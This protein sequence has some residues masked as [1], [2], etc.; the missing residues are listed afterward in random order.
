MATI[1]LL[2]NLIATQADLRTNILAVVGVGLGILA[3]LLV[4]IVGLLTADGYVLIRRLLR[5]VPENKFGICS[6]FSQGTAAPE[7]TPR[8]EDLQLDPDGSLAPKPLTTWLADELDAL[9]GI[10][11]SVRPLTMKN[12]AAKGC[13]LR[14]FTT[15]L[16]DGTPYTIPFR[17]RTFCLRSH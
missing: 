13:N 10:T 16:T 1:A 9:A 12:L 17:Q 3:G 15:N 2:A 6:G 7:D 11:D 4:A 14:M 5:A 8:G